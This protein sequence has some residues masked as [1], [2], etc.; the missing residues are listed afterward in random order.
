MFGVPVIGEFEKVHR[1]FLPS[2]INDISG[3]CKI[4]NLWYDH[5]AC[6]LNSDSDTL[7]MFGDNNVI[8]RY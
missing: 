6:L 4:K 1:N 2:N 5:F 8:K 7:D 3:D